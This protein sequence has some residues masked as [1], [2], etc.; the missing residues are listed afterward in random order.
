MPLP[1]LFNRDQTPPIKSEPRVKLEED[2]G[3]HLSLTSL[4]PLRTDPIIKNKEKVPLI[5]TEQHVD[6]KRPL[7]ALKQLSKQERRRAKKQR[8]RQAKKLRK[9]VEQLARENGNPEQPEAESK[10]LTRSACNSKGCLAEP[11]RSARASRDLEQPRVKS[12][13]LDHSSRK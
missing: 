3:E 1:F 8:Q 13:Q 12:E 10:R 5:K 9:E 7:I 4:P 6:T 2:S 11:K